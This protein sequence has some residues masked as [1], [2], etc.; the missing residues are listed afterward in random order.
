MPIKILV[1]FFVGAFG[2]VAHAQIPDV[3]RLKS[4]TPAEAKAL[5]FSRVP[6]R[7]MTPP[8]AEWNNNSLR[9]FDRLSMLNNV[10]RRLRLRASSFREA[11]IGSVRFDESD[12]RESNFSKALIYGT[13][14]RLVVADGSHF[15]G[16]R[17]YGN[18]AP[19]WSCVRCDFQNTD[20]NASSLTWANLSFAD[21]RGADLSQA[22]V[23]GVRFAGATYDSKTKLPFS[24]ERAAALGMKKVQP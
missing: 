5:P 19:S 9:N 6:H 1:A 17:F 15:N 8:M 16:A 10:F 23:A 20:F 13:S 7:A 14:F 2:L 4:M 21:L 3:E 12:L 22:D 18:K 24:D 11:R